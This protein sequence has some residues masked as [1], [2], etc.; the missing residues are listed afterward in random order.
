MARGRHVRESRRPRWFPIAVMAALVGF[1]MTLVVVVQNGSAEG[2]GRPTC[3]GK[4]TPVVV[5]AS[6]DKAPVLAKMASEF[7][8][9]NAAS[10][11]PCVEVKVSKKSSGSANQALLRGWTADDGP[12]PDVYSPTGKLW[13]PLLEQQLRAAKKDSLIRDPKAAPSMA[14]APGI[15]AMPRPMAEALGWPQKEVGWSDILT[16]AK[17]GAGW[18]DYGHPEWGKFILGKSNPTL[19]HP[20]L[21]GTIATY[22]AAV[23]RTKDL[24]LEDVGLAKTREFVAGVEQSVLRYGDTTLSFWADW[25]KA[26]ADGRALSYLSA[27]VTSE[28]LVVSYNNGNPSGDP[29]KAGDLPQPNVPLVAIYPKEGTFISDH[30]YAILDA[31][32]VTDEKRAGAEQFRDY[33][34][35]PKVQKQWQSNYFRTAKGEVSEGLGPDKGILPTQPKRLLEPLSAEVTDAVLES[36]SQLQKTANMLTLVDVSGSMNKPVGDSPET[37]LEAATGAITTAFEAF[38]ERDEVGLWAFSDVPGEAPDYRE[39]VP[40]GPMSEDLDGQVRRD[41]LDEATKALQAEGDTAMY[42]SLSAAYAAVAQRYRA[43]RINAVVLLTDGKNE[44]DGGLSLEGLLDQIKKS[45]TETPVPIIAIGYGPDADNETLARIAEATK[46][47]AYKA[48]STKDISK[49]FAAALSNF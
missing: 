41:R 35:T 37:K 38:T 42:N 29:E 4:T 27:L 28:N 8:K 31:P 12:N 14:Q 3:S 30:P 1:A 43:N 23:G 49:V 18:G 26:D 19:S 32:W 9:V 47:A 46:G 25:Q 22:Y 13:L 20:G 33:L 21:E 6:L 40:I 45:N 44:T 2:D 10:D 36:W 7:N 17:S 34:L 24:S 39:V 48:A 5:A 16:L 11:Q 15:I